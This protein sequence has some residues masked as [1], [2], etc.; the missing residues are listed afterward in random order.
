MEKRKEAVEGKGV[1]RGCR[2]ETSK[3]SYGF[4][5][6]CAAVF[7]SLMGRTSR[8]SLSEGSFRWTIK[9]NTETEEG[10]EQ[11]VREGSR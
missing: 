6:I 5:S 11:D 1:E 9:E 8:K 10:A 7:S 2:G 4:Q 3:D